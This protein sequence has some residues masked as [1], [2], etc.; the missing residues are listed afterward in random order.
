MRVIVR[1]ASDEPGLEVLR[2]GTTMTRAQWGTPI[3]VDPGTHR[4]EA[5]APHKKKWSRMLEAKGEGSV[6][7]FTVPPLED[8]PVE[9]RVAQG[10]TPPPAEPPPSGGGA[11]RVIGFASIAV[12]AGLVGTGGFFA[13]SSSSKK[14]EIEQA[15]TAGEPWSADRQA[16]YDDGESAATLANVF[17]VTGGVVLAT[18]AVL[19]VLGYAKKSST[20]SAPRPTGPSF[21]GAGVGPRGGSVAWTF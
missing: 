9:R 20:G 3:P 1:V 17:F 2:D 21:A 6:V 15:A 19:T 8:A 13:L 16:T 5:I 7:S 14:D 4:F 12:G 11:L 18:G 10:E